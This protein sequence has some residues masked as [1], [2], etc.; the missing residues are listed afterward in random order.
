MYPRQTIM[1][2]TEIRLLAEK[3]VG[4]FLDD[5]S[6]RDFYLGDKTQ[7]LMVDAM[8]SVYFASEDVQNYLKREELMK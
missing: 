1:N 6:D 5:C 8:L 3:K 7:D 4:E 2:K